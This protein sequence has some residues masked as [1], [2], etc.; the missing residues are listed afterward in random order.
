MGRK[1]IWPLCARAFVLTRQ[2]D[3]LTLVFG[4]ADGVV[5]VVATFVK[6]DAISE[7]L[8]HAVLSVRQLVEGN[9]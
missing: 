9:V 4:H 6:A 5:Q 7:S 8:A 3:C 2:C 1:R